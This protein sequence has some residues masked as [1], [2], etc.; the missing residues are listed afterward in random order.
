MTVLDGTTSFWVIGLLSFL[1]GGTLGCIVA[2]LINTRHGRTRKLQE[3]LDQLKDRFTD[4]RDQVTQH[5]MRTSE[6]VQEMTQS[7]RSVYEHLATGA[8]QL[9]GEE[10]PGPRIGAAHTGKLGTAPETGTD[11]KDV[12]LEAEACA[13]EI[14]DL[15]SEIDDLLGEEPR[16]PDLDRRAGQDNT[17]HPH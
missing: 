8:Q 2:Y 10:A 11:L 14:N 9:C 1:L 16:V 3:E 17:L 15:A 6:L 12:E 7:Y 5:F 13:A 4:Y